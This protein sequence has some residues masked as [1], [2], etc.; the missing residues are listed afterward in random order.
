MRSILATYANNV[1]PASKKIKIPRNLFILGSPPLSYGILYEV[2]EL[3]KTVREEISRIGVNHSTRDQSEF[4]LNFFRVPFPLFEGIVKECIEAN[5]FTTGR[6]KATICDEFK[7]LAYLRILGRN[8]VT[9][10]V[11]ELFGAG[12]TTINEF[13]KFFLRNYSLAYY[14]KYVF[15]LGLNE[16]E[17]VYRYM[18]LPGCIDSMDVTHVQWQACPSSAL[19]HIIALVVTVILRLVSTLFIPTIDVFNISRKF[20]MGQ[21]MIL[22]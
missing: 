2:N 8:Y 22:S 17:K 20:S 10:S 18:G 5:I 19:R 11:R 9:A 7:V 1:P 12:K 6:K 4:R 13:L 14:K 16:V 3:K 15:E 21:L